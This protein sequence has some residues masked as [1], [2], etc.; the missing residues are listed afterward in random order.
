M[1]KVMPAVTGMRYDELEITEGQMASLKY[2][3]AEFGDLPEDERQ[4]IRTGL[5]VY[6]GQDTGGMIEIIKGLSA[7]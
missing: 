6:C 1:K 2:M 4:K 7:F 5:E 3:E